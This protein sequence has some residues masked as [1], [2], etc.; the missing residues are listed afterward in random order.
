MTSKKHI[1]VIILVV[2]L[3]FGVYT[4]SAHAGIPVIDV[5]NLLENILNFV[6]NLESAIN[7]YTQIDNQVTQIENQVKGLYYQAQNLQKMDLLHSLSNLAALKSN[8]A[9]IN[10]LVLT[11]KALP[12]QY[13]QIGNRYDQLYKQ[14]DRNFT[15]YSGMSLNDMKNSASDIL[16]QTSQASYDAMTAQSMIGDIEGDES[17]LEDLQNTS[18]NSEGALDVAQAT[19]DILVLNTSQLMRLQTINAA[20]ARLQ[21]SQYEEQVQRKLITEADSQS[22]Y[23][24]FNNPSNPLQGGGSGPGFV[25]F[26]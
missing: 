23:S 7:T 4:P 19:N 21:A 26:Q 1:A 25:D 5:S 14:V 24:Y 2:C 18:D 10:Q 6:E 17:D 15:A 3:S 8:L 22:Y 13:D 11:T 9:R 20:S 12:L 16:A